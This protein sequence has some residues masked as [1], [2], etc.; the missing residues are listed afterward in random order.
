MRAFCPG[1]ITGFFTIDDTYPDVLRRGSR[2]A[3]YCV[4]AGAVADVA[5]ETDDKVEIA[6]YINSVRTAAP[7]TRR[8]VE[9][10]LRGTKGRVETTIMLDAPLNQGFGMSSAGTF[11]TCLALAHILDLDNPDQ[12]ALEATHRAEV[13]LGTGLGDAI[14]QSIGGAVFRET[15]GIGA[16]GRVRNFPIPAKE[17]CICILGDG[18][19]TKDII[20]SDEHKNIITTAGNKCLEEFLYD[21]GF[22]HFISLSNRFAKETG[23]L[24]D[25]MDEVLNILTGKG[26]MVMLG[27]AV[28]AFGDNAEVLE[29]F[30]PVMRTEISHSG[31]RLVGSD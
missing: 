31:A 8:G 18:L 20:T 28:F 19:D 15:P 17:V 14:A 30:G 21:D 27:N 7:V 4:K 29:S 16:F 25:K 23:L 2:G 5:Y 24:T 3:G 10:L 12:R 11:A 13:E 1:H 6:I 22:E 26:S 9:H